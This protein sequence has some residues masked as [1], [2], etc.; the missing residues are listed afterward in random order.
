LRSSTARR[1]SLA[2]FAV[3]AALFVGIG[4]LAI[5][6]IVSLGATNAAVEHTLLVRAEA[7]ILMS[8]LK[9]AEDGQRGYIITAQ[10][11]YL[12]PYSEAVAALP[13]RIEDF[14]RLTADNPV[15]QRYISAFEDLTTRR[16]T[17]LRDGI[18]ARDESGFEAGAKHVSSGEGKRVMDAARAIVQQMLAEED[19]LWRERGLE[20]RDREKAVATASVAS[21]ALAFL[22]LV[23]ATFFI[24]RR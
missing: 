3:S 15:Q 18:A 20:Q 7:E 22:F 6:R 14:R 2:A 21:L 23:A 1:A 16:L 5:S 8:L 12:Q 9:D 19:H 24:A 10:Q 13:K 4:A 11:M 17:M